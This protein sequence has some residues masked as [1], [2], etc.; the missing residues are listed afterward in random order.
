VWYRDELAEYVREMLLDR[1]SLARPYI[2]PQAVQRM[3]GHHLNGVGNYTM[4]IHRLL[5][6]ELT[7]RLFIDSN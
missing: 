4:E 2:V 1:R 7:H 5:A 6:L 3:V